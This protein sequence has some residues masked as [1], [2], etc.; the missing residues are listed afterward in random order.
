VKDGMDT[1][2]N[3]FYRY[4]VEANVDLKIE[5]TYMGS[6]NTWQYYTWYQGK[7]DF[8]TYKDQL[9][10]VEVNLLEGGL[11]Q[12]FKNNE[13]VEYELKMADIT[14]VVWKNFYWEVNSNPDPDP[15]GHPVPPNP[16][17]DPI[18]TG[19]NMYGV[20]VFQ[21][22]KYLLDKVTDGKILD[23]TYAFKSDF[24]SD[25][26]YGIFTHPADGTY[27]PIM[28][29]GKGL[30]GTA[31]VFKTTFSDFFK[32]FDSI[33]NL[34]LGI[35]TIAG[36]ETLVIE[37]K[38]YFFSTDAIATFNNAKNLK[39]S[40]AK[41]FI[42][43]SLKAGYGNSNIKDYRDLATGEGFECNVEVNFSM[44]VKSIKNELDI[45][46]PYLAD[47]YSINQILSL[48]GA[49]SDDT[50]SDDNIYIIMLV[51]TGGVNMLECG[52]LFNV[53]FYSPNGWGNLDLSPRR[54]IERHAD[55]LNSC[56]D[57]LA[58]LDIEFL[59]S[60]KNNSTCDTWPDVANHSLSWQFEYEPLEVADTPK[61]FKPYIIEFDTPVLED[62]ATLMQTLG[63][64]VVTVNYDD[65][66]LKGFVMDIGS[67]PIDSKDMTVKILCSPD[68]DLTLLL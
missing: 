58:G 61:L 42:F 62:M 47:Y 30:R 41:Q 49:V 24:L 3:S 68:T 29:T 18:P 64:G 59:S 45:S 8:S 28:T 56:C 12:L 20:T 66:V 65:V 44:P 4:G 14:N 57:R 50:S 27:F 2:K 25:L 55:F 35:E 51:V 48:G 5:V 52:R 6:T 67:S 23:S 13:D 17:E 39:I 43:N 40:P 32:S 46:C 19:S 1:L 53:N 10:W 38:A 60:E 21:F 11:S 36:V 54:N 34:G 31:G 16:D 22:A 63:K 7:V 9:E 15:G 26:D 33:Y 37:P